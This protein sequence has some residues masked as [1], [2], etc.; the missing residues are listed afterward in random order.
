MNF[1]FIGMPGVGKSTMG[2]RLA[3]RLGYAF[4]DTDFLISNLKRKPLQSIIESEGDAGF[5]AIEEASIL[6]L[7]GLT[8]TFISPGGSVVYSPKAMDHLRS[9]SYVVYLYDSLA[10]VEKRISNL[11]SRGIVGLNNRSL[12][13]LYQE[14]HPLYHQFA[15]ITC[16]LSKNRDSD[17]YALVEKEIE[18]LLQKNPS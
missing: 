14:R 4:L 3:K 18:C 17:N 15:H 16:D 2:K 7:K 5:I 6:S 1:T 11:A 10:H 8:K 12:A 13:E 9:I